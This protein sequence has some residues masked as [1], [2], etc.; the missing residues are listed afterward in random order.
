MRDKFTKQLNTTMGQLSKAYETRSFVKKDLK[1]VKKK[2]RRACNSFSDSDN[3][4]LYAS[5]IGNLNNVG[6]L[7]V[8]CLSCEKETSIHLMKTFKNQRNEINYFICNS[9]LFENG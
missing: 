7:L 1:R 4:K 2:E 6:N 8:C 3:I 9:C 5:R